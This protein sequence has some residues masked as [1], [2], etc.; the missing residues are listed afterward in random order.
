[1]LGF[2]TDKL[3]R[4]LEKR[5][6]IDIDFVRKTFSSD[7][8]A[9]IIVFCDGEPVLNMTDPVTAL[10]PKSALAIFSDHDVHTFPDDLIYLGVY[11]EHPVFF[12][13]LSTQ[14]QAVFLENPDYALVTLRN[15][16]TDGLVSPQ[17]ASLL[18]YARSLV[19]WHQQTR[20]CSRCGN[21]LQKTQGGL[22]QDCPA[23]ELQFFPRIDPVVIMLVTKDD[24]CLLG[25]G[26]NFPQGRFSCLAGFLETGETIEAAVRRETQEEAG[27]TVGAV[28]YK[29]SQPWPFSNQLMIGCHAEAL[30]DQINFDDQEMADVRWFSRQEAQLLLQGQLQG[31]SAPPSI[32]IAYHLIQAFINGEKP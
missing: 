10:L 2:V 8:N 28:H 14:N 9:R 12:K 3:D 27:I 11:E 24:R 31:L 6:F 29:Q 32:A 16:A 26:R 25:S 21:A 5:N 17:E 30:D 19:H 20:F 15:V 18:G 13:T 4:Q 23:C 1:M 7:P 22:R